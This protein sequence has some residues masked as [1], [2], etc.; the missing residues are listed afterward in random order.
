L[1]E[2]DLAING[3]SDNSEIFENSG[4]QIQMRR[5]TQRRRQSQT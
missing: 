5:A 4:R 3:Y 1:N 2:A